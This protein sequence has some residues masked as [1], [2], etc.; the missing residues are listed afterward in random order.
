VTHRPFWALAQGKLIGVTINATEQAAIR[1]QVSANLDLV[2]SGHLH[3]FTSYGFGGARPAQLI[4]GD[5][6]DTM[7]PLGEA[8]VPGIVID[9]LKVTQ[10]FA[11]ERFGYFVMDRNGE[12]WDGVLYGVDDAPLAHCRLAGRDLD[13][14]AG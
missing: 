14:K 13:C 12:G 1:D 4:V 3:D 10:G 6:G 5:G 7:L 8:V 2:L 11:L 9:S